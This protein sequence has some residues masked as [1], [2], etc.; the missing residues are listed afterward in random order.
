MSHLLAVHGAI[1]SGKS[2]LVNYVQQA[3][4]FRVV[5]FADPMKAM[6]WAGLVQWM[7]SGDSA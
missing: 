6:L 5:N 7:P 4:G 3:Y 1:G 2:T